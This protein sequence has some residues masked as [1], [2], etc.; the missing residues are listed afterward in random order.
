MK[1]V[2]MVGLSPT[3]QNVLLGSSPKPSTIKILIMVV[4]KVKIWTRH[5]C[6]SYIE[7]VLEFLNEK[8]IAKEDVWSITKNSYNKYIVIYLETIKSKIDEK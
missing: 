1:L 3:E 7:S 8:N 2:N 4:K 5:V 6:G